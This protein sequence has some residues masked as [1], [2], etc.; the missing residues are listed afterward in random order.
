MKRMFG[1]MAKVIR[2]E[3]SYF[4]RVIDIFEALPDAHRVGFM[5]KIV[6]EVGTEKW[7]RKLK[8]AMMHRELILDILFHFS[9]LREHRQPC[10]SVLIRHILDYIKSPEYEENDKDIVHH[11][12]FM[13]AMEVWK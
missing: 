10:K 7:E 3:R 13:D 6:E 8:D 11:T 5:Q 1:E 4:A 9:G 12:P 2:D